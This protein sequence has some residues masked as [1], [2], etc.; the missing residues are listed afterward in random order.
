MVAHSDFL[1]FLLSGKV[2]GRGTE[3]TFVGGDICVTYNFSPVFK[4]VF[5][6]P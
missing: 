5:K 2:S 6:E 3:E 1:I 4:E